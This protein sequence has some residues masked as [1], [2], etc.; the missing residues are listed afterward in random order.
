MADQ[1]LVVGN[2][3][4]AQYK[5]SPAAKPMCVKT[6]PD[7]NFLCHD[8]QNRSCQ[9]GII[10]RTRETINNRTSIRAMTTYGHCSLEL[11][12]RLRYT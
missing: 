1:P 4:T 9:F 6:M 12:H 10:T 11:A 5:F 3:D 2:L 7:A 8:L